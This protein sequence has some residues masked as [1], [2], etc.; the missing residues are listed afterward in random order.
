M[1]N[2]L[3]HLLRTFEWCVMPFRLT[4]APATFQHLINNIFSDLLD[5]CILVYLDDILIY[6]DTLEEH[7]HHIR[8][9]LLW[10]QTNKL[11]ARGDKCAFHED[12]IDYLGFILSPNG[13]SMDP[14]KVSAILE[15]PEPCKVKDIQSFLG[16]ANFYRRFISDY[17]KITVPLTCLT[18]KGTPWD[19]SD[20]CRSSFESLKKAFTTAP[21]LARWSPGD[22]L[23]VE[24]N[25]S[26]YALGAILSTIDPSDNQVHPIA[27]HSRTFTSP[28]LNYNVHNKELLAMFEAFK[29]WRHYLE[30]TPTPIDVITDH[31][32]LKHFLTT[33]VLTQ[34]HA[35]WSEFLSQFNL[36]I[37]FHPGKLGT[38]PDMLTRQWDIYPKEGERSYAAVNPHN[39]RPV[40]T[41]EQLASSLQATVLYALVLQATT[42]IDLETLYS[43]IRSALHSDPA[44]SK[45]LSNP[46]LRWTIDT[47]GLLRLDNC[48]YIPDSRSLRLRVLQYKHDHPIS[49]HFGHNHTL[50]LIRQEF[51]WP[52]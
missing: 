8:E 49:G 48:I 42:I 1:E 51:V 22:P 9:V 35:R 31:K 34:R 40:F 46:T 23:I 25:V 39:F 52:V 21:V 16:F 50:D 19:F 27:F 33:K 11:Y 43:D 4:N 13:L 28:E 3:P 7:H 38:K 12:T 18:C 10:L 14:S 47:S 26:D 30:G 15:W 32:N 5:I 29:S 37:H 36:M 6:S 41:N 20:I 17:S 24:T 2:C 45:Q 44:I